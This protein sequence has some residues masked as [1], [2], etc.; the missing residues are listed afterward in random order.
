[1]GTSK[2]DS[3]IFEMD[4]DFSHNPK[5]LIRLYKEV[6]DKNADMAMAQD[7]LKELIL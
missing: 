2:K 5:D 1:M 4:A 7:M 3:F 6:K